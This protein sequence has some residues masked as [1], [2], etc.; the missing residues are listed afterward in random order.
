MFDCVWGDLC[1]IGL[2]TISVRKNPPPELSLL[3]PIPGNIE[4]WR[5]LRFDTWGD[6]KLA[7]F[8]CKF[9]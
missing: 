8:E 1:K 6:L 5:F 7:L 4:A 9:V 3:F 2:S